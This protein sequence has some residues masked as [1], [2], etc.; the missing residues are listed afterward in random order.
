LRSKRLFRIKYIDLDNLNTINRH[1][2]IIHTL[3]EC[4]NKN[5]VEFGIPNGKL[6]ENEHFRLLIGSNESDIPTSVSCSCGINIQLGSIRG[7]IS[8][9]NYYKHLKS[10]NC[11]IKKKISKHVN[12]ESNANVDGES[13]DAERS[14]NTSI[15]EDI[16]CLTLASSMD[17]PTTMNISCKRTTDQDNNN[18]SKTKR[19]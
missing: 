16:Q 15:I 7:N 2:F 1:D 9:G 10:K 5:G 18:F 6:I 17:K 14:E 8:L 19:I 13:F 4:I 3:N 11:I 12:D